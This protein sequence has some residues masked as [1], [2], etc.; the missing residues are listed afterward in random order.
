MPNSEIPVQ[1]AE[2]QR[3]LEAFHA[4]HQE[5]EAIYC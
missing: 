2:M 4:I 3:R 5:F 1:S